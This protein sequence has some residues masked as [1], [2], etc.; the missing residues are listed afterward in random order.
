MNVTSSKTRAGL[1]LGQR[2]PLITLKKSFLLTKTKFSRR[3]FSTKII[4]EDIERQIKFFEL[5]TD[6]NLLIVSTNQNELVLFRVFEM[7]GR[8][9]QESKTTLD[10]QIQSIHQIGANR[11]LAAVFDG[12]C[13]R[14][15]W[16]N[17]ESLQ[18]TFRMKLSEKVPL[19]HLV[20]Y[21]Q[22]YLFVFVP[23]LSKKG[24]SSEKVYLFD[25]KHSSPRKCFM[26]SGT[27]IVDCCMPTTRNLFVGC[28]PNELKFFKT[29]FGSEKPFL[30]D[31]TLKLKADVKSLETFHKNHS[32]LL[33]NCVQTEASESS[34]IFIVNTLRR[35]IIN[36]IT[37]E[38][39]TLLGFQI[40]CLSTV[41][42][43][44]K[45][46]EIYLV[47]FDDGKIRIC[48]IDSNRLRD[49]IEPQGDNRWRLRVDSGN[50]NQVKML[51]QKSNGNIQF[52]A[53][54]EQGIAL[55]ELN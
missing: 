20:F 34:V 23:C 48:D 52:V 18:V 25:A 50:G 14:L 9:S 13:T 4:L 45:K 31:Y 37:P 32:I 12:K 49:R 51:A 44:C 26:L 2:L 8:V 43:L 30:F 40:K 3:G 24:V 38:N 41:T 54:T 42:V 15:I 21:D 28:R 17:P 53:M 22:N 11:L 27:Q 6:L 35:E 29:D 1:V 55:V 36:K 7:T 5:F 39:S 46:P 16:L 47:A 33:A 19:S 10:G